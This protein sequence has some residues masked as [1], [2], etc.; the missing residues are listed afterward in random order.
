[1]S[2]IPSNITLHETSYLESEYSLFKYRSQR[3]VGLHVGKGASIYAGSMFDLGIDGRVQVG[4]YALLNG[5][6]IICD[7]EVSIGNHALISWNVVI[8]D[9]HRVSYD[10][11][12]RRGQLEAMARDREW[13]RAGNQTARPV[14]IGSNV[15]IGFDTCILPGVSI[16]ESA[17]IGARSVVG[18]DVA[19]YSVV[20]GNPVR[21]IRE[22]QGL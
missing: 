19:P 3:P 8:M 4:A 6:W 21:L 16:G 22:L 9:S 20:G 14:M 11:R 17:V 7:S 2:K 13:S 12:V 10:P 18:E 15:W 5:A 1:M